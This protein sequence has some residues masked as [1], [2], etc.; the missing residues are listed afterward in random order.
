VAVPFD[1]LAG[2]TFARVAHTHGLYNF[3][4]TIPY[5]YIKE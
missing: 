5:S 1:A 4:G 2:Y 3:K